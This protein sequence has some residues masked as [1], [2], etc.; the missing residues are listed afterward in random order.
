MLSALRGMVMVA[1]GPMM[2]SRKGCMWSAW[3]KTTVQ[4]Y[5]LSG[6]VPSSGVETG[7]AEGD[8]HLRRHISL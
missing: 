8:R 5:A 1:S 7:A 2:L 6:S 4:L 3:W